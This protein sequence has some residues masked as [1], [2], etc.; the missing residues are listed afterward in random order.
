MSVPV[1]DGTTRTSVPVAPVL[2]TPGAIGRLRPL[3]AAGRRRSTGGFWAERLR[4]NRERTLPHAFEQLVEAG[5]LENFR[6]AAGPRPGRYRALGIMFDGPFPFL[7]SDVYK[8]LEGVGLGARAGVGRRHR[9]DG[10]PGDRR[11]SPRRSATTATSTRSSRSWRRAREYRDLQF[12]HELY[13]IGHLVQAAVA[14]HR[15][16][17]DDRLLAVARRAADSV[18]AAL[19]PD[20]ADGIDGHPEIEMA[21]VELYRVTGEARYLELARLHIDRRGH[22]RLGS[23]RFGG[24]YWQDVEP[25]REA[26]GVAGH[27]VRQLYLDAGAIDVA[28]ETGDAALLD[29]VHARW[30]DMVATR[31]YLTGGLGSRH[32]Q[33]AFGDPYELPPD[34]AYTETCA[35]IAS[36]MVAWRL[37]LATGDPDAADAIERTLY[38]GV[39]SGVSSDGNRFFYVNPLQRRTHRVAAEPGTGERKPWYACACCPPNLVRT[40]ASW[41]QILATT[42]GHGLQV[43]QYA[44][45]EIAAS[46]GGGRVRLAVETD[47]PWSGRVRIAVVEA[48]DGRVDPQLCGSRPGRRPATIDWGDGQRARTSRPATARCTRR[49]AVAGRRRRRPRARDARPDHRARAPGR[50][51]PGLRSRSSAARSSTPSRPPTC[52]PAW[53]VE[54]VRA[55]PRRPPEPV[56]RPDLGPGVIGLSVGG[57]DRGR[58][59]ARPRGGPLPRVG[60]PV[61]RGDAGLDPARRPAR[62]RPATPGLTTMALAD[63][64]AAVAA[65]NVALGRSGLVVL[66]FGNVS[67]V[68]RDGRRP[69]HQAL[70][71]ALRRAHGRTTWWSW[72]STTGR[73]S[74]ATSARPPTRPRTGSCIASCRASA[75]WSTR[76]PARR[77]RGPRPGARSRASA[78]PTRTTSGGRCR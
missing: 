74:R 49:R 61:G 55:R 21:L 8:W 69:R 51:D 66:S 19:G 28:V 70:G 76:T 43:H 38:N 25:V 47:Y 14:W 64:K 4:T 40:F 17:G 16:L 23:G 48:P 73:W 22:G 9:G 12:G 72:R 60:Q 44:A 10:R 53:S 6:L 3:G 67:G 1:G 52:P 36:V 18:D 37:L 24:A 39:L 63:L 46:V 71:R 68:D 62:L 30:Q 78:P 7:D 56:A 77:R 54:D 11:S 27:A 26:R 29:A 5:N 35:A 59:G 75:G 2:P 57:D 42:D 58:R 31:T 13:C 15:A 45:G 32:A 34:R 41:P 50:R 20:G 33:E 65:A